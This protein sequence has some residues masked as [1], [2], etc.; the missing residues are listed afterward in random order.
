M[1]L[2]P[3]NIVL[4]KDLNAILIDTSGIGGTTRKWLSPEMRHQPNPL[5]Q[6]IEARKQN[7]IWA[8]GQI[9]WEMAQITGDKEEHRVLSE[10]SRLAATEDTPRIPLGDIASILSLA[11]A[12]PG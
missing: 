9:L 1:D 6:D 7:D 4:S 11:S 10:V 12:L 5:A 2:K 8:V 3:E